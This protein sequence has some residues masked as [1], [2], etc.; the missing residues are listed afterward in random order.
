MTVYEYT[1]DPQRVDLIPEPENPKDPKAIKVLVDG[2]HV[3]YI[4]A[5]SCAHIHRLIRENRIESIEPRIL[6]G[7]YKAV[8]SYDAS[9]RK[10]EDFELEKGTS[11]LCVRLDITELPA[12]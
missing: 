7:K 6:G 12:G 4:K 8:F 9:A 1:F 3:G 5:G 2:V 11:P 10:A